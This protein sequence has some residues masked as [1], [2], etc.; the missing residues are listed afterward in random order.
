MPGNS[1]KLEPGTVVQITT[2]T[3]VYS[4]KQKYYTLCW[5]SYSWSAS[6]FS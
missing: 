1:V 6:T 5:A 2:A 3:S 4:V